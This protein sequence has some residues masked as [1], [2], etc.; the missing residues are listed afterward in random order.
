MSTS[1]TVVVKACITVVWLQA[2]TL[3]WLALLQLSAFVSSVSHLAGSALAPH[4]LA[5][6]VLAFVRT[7]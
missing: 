7:C 6:T 5:G 4:G 1:S 2:A 3:C